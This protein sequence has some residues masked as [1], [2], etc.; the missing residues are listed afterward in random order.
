M[1][2]T[3]VGTNGSP[4]G[5]IPGGFSYVARFNDDLAVTATAVAGD[6]RVNVL[7][8]PRVQTSHAVE[9]NLFVGQTRPYPT[10]SSYGGIYGGYNSIQQLQ[11]GITLSVLPLINP[12]GLVVMD[13]RQRTQNIGDEVLIQNVGLVPST[14]DREA[15]AK[16]AVRDRETVVLG[17]FI[18]SDRRKSASG[19]PILKD[20]PVLGNLFR[21]TS[22]KD[23]RVELMILIRP[24]VLPTPH[25]AAL[26][27]AEEKRTMTGVA[28]AERDFEKE[29]RK[30]QKKA[31]KELNSDLYKREGFSE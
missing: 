11:I 19:V 6:S 22:K 30:L 8:R 31:E 16:V 14:I 26:I 21:G 2:F 23:Q 25:D 27:V 1:N 10:G 29:E 5:N 15:N 20:I 18:S 7:S 13:I 3:G 24:T 4:G 9:A 12:D 28:T 17:G